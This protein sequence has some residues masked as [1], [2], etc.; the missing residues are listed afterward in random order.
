MRIGPSGVA[1][2]LNTVAAAL[3]CQLLKVIFDRCSNTPTTVARFHNKIADAGK[4][5]FQC[6]LGDE[7]NGDHADGPSVIFC[8]QQPGIFPAS[9]L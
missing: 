4:I 9:E 1:V 8:N 6:K 2:D 3:A 7:M 5:T